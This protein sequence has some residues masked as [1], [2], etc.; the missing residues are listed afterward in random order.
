[1][2]GNIIINR[3]KT[4]S[5]TGHRIMLDGFDEESLI[6]LIKGAIKDGYDTFLVGMALGFDTLCFKILEDLRQTNDIKIIACV[7]CPDQDK[8]FKGED[9]IIYKNMIESAD[10]RV[11]LSERYTP[12]CMQ[13]RNRFMVDNSSIVIAYVKRNY[14][15]SYNTVK[16]AEKQNIKIVKL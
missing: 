16:Y 8:S 5:F 14:G 3:A 15:G 6:N 11:V 9:K 1:M 13:K 10:E 2:I 4:C 7:P 12:Y